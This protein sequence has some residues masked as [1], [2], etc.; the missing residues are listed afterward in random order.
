MENLITTTRRTTFIV[1]E[2]PF[3]GLKNVLGEDLYDVTITTQQG[4][5]YNHTM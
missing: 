5:E 3:P 2:D 1:L 4:C